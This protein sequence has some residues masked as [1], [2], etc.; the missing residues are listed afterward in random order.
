MTRNQIHNVSIM[1]QFILGVDQS[2]TGTSVCLM[3]AAGQIVHTVECDH[4]QFYPHQ[5]WFEQGP[6]QLCQM[7]TSL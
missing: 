6:I 1:D 3:N 7:Y 4:E 5:G 2:T